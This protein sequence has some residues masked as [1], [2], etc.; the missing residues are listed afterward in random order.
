M[1]GTEPSQTPDLA[2][3]VLRLPHLAQPPDVTGGPEPLSPRT[4][5]GSFSQSAG[6]LCQHHDLA[7]ETL[8]GCLTLHCPPTGCNHNTDPLNP[9]RSPQMLRNPA[10]GV[11]TEA[12]SV[13]PVVELGSDRGGDE[14]PSTASPR[15]PQAGGN[16]SPPHHGLCADTCGAGHG[17]AKGN[18]CILHNE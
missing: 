1:S 16:G 11:D 14:W 12:S 9:T 18:K 5:S 13:L 10:V 15:L 7:E 3:P 4:S 8:P 17:A 6:G 2:R